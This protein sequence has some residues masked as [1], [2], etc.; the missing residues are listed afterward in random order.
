MNR[1]TLIGCCRCWCRTSL[2]QPSRHG[3]DFAEDEECRLRARIVRRRILL[4]KVIVRLQQQGINCT[5]VQNL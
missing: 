5:S 3:P 2:T 4:S 1:R